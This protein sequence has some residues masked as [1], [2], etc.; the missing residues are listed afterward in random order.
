M[1]M[2]TYYDLKKML[3]KELDDITYKSK[4]G[5]IENEHDLDIIDKLTH[6]I[7]S[8]ETV[9]AMK[10]AQDEGESGYT[11]PHYMGDRRFV[12]R[13]NRDDDRMSNRMS[14]RGR[15]NA[16]R[17]NAMG[18]YSREDNRGYSGNTEE[19]MIEDLR[20]LMAEAKDEHTRMK[21]QRFIEDLEER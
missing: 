15:S 8:L 1:G 18:Q 12:D 10:E 5:R 9:I 11:I 7:K 17:R 3:C 20:D 19:E 16:Q 6:S 21:F 14:R 13:S 2:Q 4:N